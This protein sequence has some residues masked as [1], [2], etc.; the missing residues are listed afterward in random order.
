[1]GLLEFL[2]DQRSKSDLADFS[3]NQWGQDSWQAKLAQADPESFR[4][5][6]PTQMG[7]VSQQSAINQAFPQPSSQPTVVPQQVFPIGAGGSGD[8][9]PSAPVPQSLPTQDFSPLASLTQ[10]QTIPAAP[11]T[12]L[13]RMMAN[14]SQL[15]PNLQAVAAQMQQYGGGGDGSG[16]SQIEPFAQAVAD[17]KMPLS[18][19]SRN[20]ALQLAVKD[21]VLAINPDYDETKYKERQNVAASMAPGGNIGQ[22]LTQVQTAI[23]HLAAYK[24]ASDNLGG[25]NAGFLSQPIN[26]IGNYFRSQNPDLIKEQRLQSMAGDEVA[27][28]TAGSSG[29]TE[30]DRKQQQDLLSITQSPQARTAAAQ[31][32]VQTMFGKLEPIADQYN[33]AYGKNIS[34][35]DLL[36]DETKSSLAKLG[37]LPDNATPP[38]AG[39]SSALAQMSPQ[40]GGITPAMAQAELARRA[41]ARG[42]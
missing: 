6:L 8:Q 12:P 30:A 14:Y 24:T 29:G 31:A 17:Y 40:S 37:M 22:K 42:R 20:P 1:M 5:I 18:N 26:A 9:Q 28:F 32:A 4:Q 11:P 38:A 21:M 35:A 10:P 34:P 15:P 3:A 13:Q 16:G 27:R 2:A 19:L 7:Q 41:A 36:S 25:V 23:N 39:G 33:K